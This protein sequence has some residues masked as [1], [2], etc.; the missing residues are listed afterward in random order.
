MTASTEAIARET[1]ARHERWEED[2]S[3]FEQFLKGLQIASSRH[4]PLPPAVVSRGTISSDQAI[5]ED[6]Y[7]KW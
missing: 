4:R 3:K 7:G 2:S 6:R 1:R 5:A